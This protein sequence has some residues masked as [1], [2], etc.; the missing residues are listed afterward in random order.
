MKVQDM[1]LLAI[2]AGLKKML[3]PRRVVFSPVMMCERVDVSTM[4]IEVDGV[5]YVVVAKKE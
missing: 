1:M 2:E 3:S 5:M 4:K